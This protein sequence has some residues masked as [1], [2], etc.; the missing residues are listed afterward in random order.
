[1]VPVFSFIAWSGIG[2][3]TY[4]EQLTAELKS[5]G[6]RVAVLKH[7]AHRFE[8]DKQGKDSQR[9]AAAGADVVAI[10]DAEKWA[11]LEYRPASFEDILAKITDVDMVL[12]EGWHND[13]KNP[14]LVH[15]A[16]AGKPLKLDPRTCFAVVSDTPLETAGRP[17]FP[18][19]NPVPMADY[20]VD[21]LNR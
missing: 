12:V 15:R 18:L 7:D 8:I 1:M 20:L 17:L 21:R 19:D 11:L 4:L 14:V 6:L 13:A 3:T 10:A 5:R 9:F 16:A 2:K